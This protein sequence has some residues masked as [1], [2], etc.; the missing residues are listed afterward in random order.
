MI[1]AICGRRW[2]SGQVRWKEC[3]QS[4]GPVASNPGSPW[5]SQSKINPRPGFESYDYI[6]CTVHII[7]SSY[8]YSSY[9]NYPWHVSLSSRFC[10]YN[11]FSQ[12]WTGSVDDHLELGFFLQKKRFCLHIICSCWMLLM[13]WSCFSLFFSR[14]LEPFRVSLPQKEQAAQLIASMVRPDPRKSVTP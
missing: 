2:L 3:A 9:G 14:T 12:S 1:S 7:I 11:Y 13:R 10:V 6:L 5:T 8:D 4:S